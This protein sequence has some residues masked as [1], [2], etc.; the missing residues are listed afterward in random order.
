MKQKIEAEAERI[1]LK[2][3]E[4]YYRLAYSYVKNEQD[5]LDI[6]QESAYRVIKECRK[7]RQE[8]YLSTWIYRIVI[9]ASIDYLRKQKTDRVSLDEVEIPQEDHYKED[10]YLELLSSLEEKDRTIVIL[11]YIEEWKLEEIAEILE[12][13]VS[14]VKARLY[15]ALKKL[16]I[17]LEPEA[18]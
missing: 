1:L 2:N 13:N 5:A 3:Y 18:T 16:K 9:N 11:K 4:S 14:T 12:M 6:V 15:R 17:V 10:D 8:N 7:L